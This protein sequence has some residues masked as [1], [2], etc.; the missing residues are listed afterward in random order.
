[1]IIMLSLFS[2]W[3]SPADSL[4]DDSHKGP[5]KTQK[6]KSVFHSSYYLKKAMTY[7]NKDELQLALFY[8]KIAAALSPSDM[9]IDGKITDL[10]MT[11]DRK[12]NN[13]LKKGAK[14]LN[15]NNIEEA[16]N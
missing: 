3:A 10:K 13:Y 4:G 9:E 15:R 7:K 16:R 12:S 2:G 6:N 5:E 11:I 14:F 1:M 8:L